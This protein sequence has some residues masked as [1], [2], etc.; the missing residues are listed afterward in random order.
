MPNPNFNHFT[1]KTKSFQTRKRKKKGTVKVKNKHKNKYEKF[2]LGNE[3]TYIPWRQKK[4]LPQ[5]VEN[6]TTGKE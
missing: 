2:S 1:G 5:E 6:L 4:P 3:P